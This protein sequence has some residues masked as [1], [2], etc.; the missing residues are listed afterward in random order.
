MSVWKPPTSRFYQFDFQ[1]RGQRF[2]GSTGLT[3]KRDAE[4]FEA[5]RR[6][7]VAL[8]TNTRPEITLDAG[9][10]LFWKEAGQTD[11]NASDTLYQLGN[12]CRII[13]GRKHMTTIAATDFDEYRKARQKG[14]SPRT[15]RPLSNAT[16]NRE[17]EVA[18]RVWKLVKK[19]NAVSE[20][21]WGPLMLKEPLER[22]RELKPQEEVALHEVLWGDLGDV[23]EFAM[24]SGARRTE[25]IELEK[26]RIDWSGPRASV[27]KKG[28]AEHTFPLTSR[29]VVLILAQPPVADCP[30]VFTYTCRRPTT[31]HTDPAKRRYKG[32]RYP[33]SKQGW[34]RDWRKALKEAGISDFRFHD[35]RHTSATRLVRATNGN[36]KAAQKLLGHTNITTTARYAHVV[37]DDLR[38]AMADTESR[39]SPKRS[40]TNR[41]K[42]GRK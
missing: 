28:G 39:N 2:Y 1:F 22:V 29:M 12:L 16:I 31:G 9:C 6:R 34:M 26:A 15:K 19:T 42:N 8:G 17:L 33:F 20:I 21:E 41:A 23:V 14:V 37:E 40:L 4:R 30:Y 3:A 35:L 18:R 7:E 25:V 27:T 38:N 24:L 11:K 36:L 5:D 32:R 10:E 13:G